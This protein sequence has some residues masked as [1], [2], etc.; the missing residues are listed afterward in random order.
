MSTPLPKDAVKEIVAN[1]RANHATLSSCVGPHEFIRV[2]PHKL[3]SRY[4]CNKCGGTV[5]TTDA[6]WYNAGLIHGRA[7]R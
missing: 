2:E 5:S 1:V 7:N 4:R 3:F 6:Q